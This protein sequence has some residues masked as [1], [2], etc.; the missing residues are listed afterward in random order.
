MMLSRY[1]VVSVV[2]LGVDWALFVVLTATMP[3]DAGI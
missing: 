3:I 1:C 2:S